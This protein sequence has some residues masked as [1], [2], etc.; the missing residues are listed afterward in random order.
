M[1]TLNRLLRRSV[2]PYYP[3]SRSRYSGTFPLGSARR[4]VLYTTNTSPLNSL[5]VSKYVLSSPKSNN[6]SI[7]QDRRLWHPEGAYR[8]AVSKT[9]S[10]PR[11]TESRPGPRSRFTSPS[12]PFTPARRIERDFI[13]TRTGEILSF[14]HLDP[15]KVSWENPWKMLIC[16]KRKMRR[17]VM[18]AFGMAGKSGFKKPKFTPMSYVRCF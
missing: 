3:F 2:T 9:E 13:D 7:Y 12:S 18:H 10:Y 8:P 15:F 5:L 11:L 4:G 6:Q 17:E 1:P 16:L 14:G